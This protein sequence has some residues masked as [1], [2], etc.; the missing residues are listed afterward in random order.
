MDVLAEADP[1]GESV[2]PVVRV[3]APDPDAIQTLAVVRGLRADRTLRGRVGS[4]DPLEQSG[5]RDHRGGLG[6]GGRLS[7][8]VDTSALSTSG[9]AAPVISALVTHADGTTQPIRISDKQSERARRFAVTIPCGDDGCALTG[10][11]IDSTPGSTVRTGS[12][13]LGDL[14]TLAGSVDLGAADD[15]YGPAPMESSDGETGGTLQPPATV[16]SDQGGLTLDLS[17]SGGSSIQVT[18]AW[19]PQVLPA[20]PVGPTTTADGDGEP[21]FNLNGLDG[22][23]RPA[24][25]KGRA[26]A[27]PGAP[28][29]VAIVDLESAL[30][31]VIVTPQARTSLWFADDDRSLLAEVTDELADAGIQVTDVRTLADAQRGQEESLPSWSLQACRRTRCRLLVPGRPGGDRGRRIDL[32][33]SLTRPGEHDDGRS[34]NHER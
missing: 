18:H 13:Q 12:V 34:R 27:V 31:G 4:D 30:R 22:L 19:I 32:A 8:T 1:D 5:S 28:E 10:F 29:N 2:T 7:G 15:W 6:D 23:S 11:R 25:E 14:K 20:A 3:P 33:P 26:D 24:L 21:R 9:T 17:S 16:S